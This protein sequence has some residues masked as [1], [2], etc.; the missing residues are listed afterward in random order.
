MKKIIIAFIVMFS[1][2][3]AVAGDAQVQAE[4]DHLLKTVE[5]S[6]CAFIRNGK[7]HSAAEAADHILKKYDHFKAKIR[8][9]EDFIDYCASKS[10]LSNQ[11][12]KIA[13]P[14]QDAVDSKYW[15]LDE[16]KRF[17]NQ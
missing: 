5:N 7:T 14:D 15:F 2:W 16:L 17:R 9:T 10:M 6:N 11:P 3:P 8:T 12:Y 1:A 13:C 4:I